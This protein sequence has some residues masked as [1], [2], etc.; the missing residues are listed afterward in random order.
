MVE[1]LLTIV[2]DERENARAQCFSLREQIHRNAQRQ[3]QSTDQV[4]LAGR[5]LIVFA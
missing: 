2:L 5:R 3:F 1:T 4:V